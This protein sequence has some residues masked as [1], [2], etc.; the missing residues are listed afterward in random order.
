VKRTAHYFTTG[1]EV[2]FMMEETLQLIV[3]QLKE[4]KS[5]VIAGQEELKCDIRAGQGSQGQP[6]C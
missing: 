4:Y 1:E 5:V 6:D 2:G 3:E